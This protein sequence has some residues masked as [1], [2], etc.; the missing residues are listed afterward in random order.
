MM[1]IARRLVVL[2]VPAAIAVRNPFAPDDALLFAKA[3][4]AELCQNGQIETASS[5]ARRTLLQ[6]NPPT[7]SFAIPM[8]FLR[9]AEGQMWNLKETAVK[10]SAGKKSF[11]DQWQKWVVL[12]GTLFAILGAV[13]DLPAKLAK[14]SE[15]RL[16]NKKIIASRTIDEPRPQILE[17]QIVDE[18]GA[19]IEG[20]KVYLPE[21]DKTIITNDWGK[22]KFEII[23]PADAR[24]KLQAQKTGYEI[25]NQDPALG[26]KPD[27]FQM[28]PAGIQP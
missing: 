20:V 27:T 17:G 11:L 28:H 4:Y 1:D 19:P 25:L 22:Y 10:A 6:K 26:G 24:V 23:A 9:V 2:G 18:N 7:A 21:Y 15:L 5:S 13:L 16:S 8:L 12:I 14:L 3:L